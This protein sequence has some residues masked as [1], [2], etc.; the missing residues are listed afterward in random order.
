MADVGKLVPVKTAEAVAAIVKEVPVYQDAI[1]PAA[2]E[3][4]MLA[5]SPLAMLNTALRPVKSIMLGINLTL[6]KLDDS[7]RRLLAD[8]P[9]EQVVEPRASVAGPLL[10]AYPFVASEPELQEMFAR[11][12][13]T[14]MTSTTQGRAHPAF[15]E[16]MKQL[17]A[18]EARLVRRFTQPFRGDFPAAELRVHQLHGGYQKRGALFDFGN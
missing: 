5:A 8:V 9:P 6:D 10:L 3:L 7:L 15:V 14:A 12:L 17:T 16:I 18:D 2:R 1:Q 11:L 13:A 4:G